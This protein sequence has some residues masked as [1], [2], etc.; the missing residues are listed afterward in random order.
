MWKISIYQGRKKNGMRGD[1]ETET[2][3]SKNPLHLPGLICQFSRQLRIP[4]CHPTLSLWWTTTY[5]WDIQFPRNL[6]TGAVAAQICVVEQGWWR[7]EVISAHL[8]VDGFDPAEWRHW[9]RRRV[10]REV[11]WKPRSHEILPTSTRAGTQLSQ[12]RTAMAQ[13]SV[14]G[15]S[16]WLKINKPVLP[17]LGRLTQKKHPEFEAA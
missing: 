17:T 16:C 2:I 1:P 6:V 9:R 4:Q 14:K 7:W 3:Q 15:S 5:T 10:V 12:D 8:C 13:A 11:P